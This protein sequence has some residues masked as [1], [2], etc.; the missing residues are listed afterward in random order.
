MEKLFISYCHKDA[1]FVDR[2][3]KDLHSE[4]KI[5]I[6]KLK[7]QPSIPLLEQIAAN[8]DTAH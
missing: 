6:D 2:L 3:V 4:Y 7:V 8:I 1:A 5:W